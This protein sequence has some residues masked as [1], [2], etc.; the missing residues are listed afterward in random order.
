MPAALAM[1]DAV[2]KNIKYRKA[3]R[4]KQAYT[5]ITKPN[6]NGPGQCE[7]EG[8]A[9]RTAKGR[10]AAARS[11]MPRGNR[12]PEAQANPP[13]N[14]LRLMPNVPKKYTNAQ[15]VYE[16]PEVVYDNRQKKPFTQY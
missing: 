7:S 14:W 6:K 3:S 12:A 9:H 10:H 4:R 13:D 5:L 16:R 8:T 15:K 11:T 1:S 2:G